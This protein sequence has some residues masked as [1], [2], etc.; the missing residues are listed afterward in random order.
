MRPDERWGLLLVEVQ[1]Q[2]TRPGLYHALIR[3]QLESRRVL[4]NIEALARGARASGAPVVHAPLVLDPAAKRGWLAHLTF[5]RVFTRGTWKA[6]I[7]SRFVEPADEVVRGRCAFDAFEGSDLEAVLRRLEIARVYLCGF[8]TDQCVA[9]TMRTALSKGFD[10]HVVT[11]GTATLAG[12][13][14]RRAELAFAPRAST[15]AEV[16]SLLATTSAWNCQ[17]DSGAAPASRC[18]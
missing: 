17:F 9:R 11:D 18:R 5:G 1:G 10:A 15:A 6:E 12:F 3:R 2:W 4:D 7:P 14:Q 16:L 13:Q 8:T